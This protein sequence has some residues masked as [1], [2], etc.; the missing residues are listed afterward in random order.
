[1]DASLL[2]EDVAWDARGERFLV[3]SIHR[4]KIVA[5]DRSGRVT[6]FT[7]AGADGAWLT[8]DD[9]VGGR[10]RYTYDV[11][12]LRESVTAL[13]G[14][15]ADGTWETADDAISFYEV[16]AHDMPGN[17]TASRVYGHP[18]NDNIWK[19]FDDRITN[20]NDYDLAH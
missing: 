4:R 13:T 11:T 12:R 3:S 16:L 9:T 10:F 2:A 18:G 19:T 15:G 14:P 5:V 20:E 8:A 17:R 7:A 1:V 6:D